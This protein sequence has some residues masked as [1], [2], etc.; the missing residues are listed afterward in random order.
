MTSGERPEFE[1]PGKLE[2]VLASLSVYY[3]Q[4]GKPILQKLLVN[5]RYRVREGWDYDNWNGGTWGHAVYFHVPS[6][7]YYQIFDDLGG[8]VKEL[9]TGLNRVS[10]V[11]NE[12]VSEV[13]L[14]LQ[15]EPELENWRDDSGVLLHGTPF[16]VVTSDDQLRRLWAPGFLRVFITHKAEYRKEA[17]RLKEALTYY[18]ASSFVAHEDIEPTKEWQDEIERALFSMDGLVA[19]LTDGFADSMWTDQEVGVAIGRGTPVVPVRMGTDPYGLI[20]KY[21]ALTGRG[22]TPKVLAK[23]LFELF[24]DKPGLEGQMTEAMVSRFERAE[25]FDQANDLMGYLQGIQNAPPAI[26]ER[27]AKAPEN[28]SQV[29]GAFGV[30][31][32][33]TSLLQKL[34]GEAQAPGKGI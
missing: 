5:S 15:D 9:R 12:Y 2:K 23:K 3:A 8:I 18:G 34:R 14:E 30:R 28:N 24:L 25:N 19:M 22:K 7:I 4:H 21:Q 26:I 10:N 6:V 31:A 11:Q 13:F 1:L 33:L 29:K 27:L 17:S 20:G 32:Q 16:S